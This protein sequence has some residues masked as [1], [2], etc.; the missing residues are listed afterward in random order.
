MKREPFF[1]KT[2]LAGLLFFLFDFQQVNKG[3]NKMCIL[4][5]TISKM[6]RNIAL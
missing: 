5:A 2:F 3:V 4:I 6:F 1:L